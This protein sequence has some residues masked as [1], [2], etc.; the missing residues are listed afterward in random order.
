MSTENQVHLIGDFRREE[1][2]AAGTIT[3]GMLIEEDSSGEFQAHSTEGGYAMRLFAE[4]DAL[5][6]NTLDD[7]YSADDLVS[8]NVELPGNE[9][10][11]FLQAGEDVDI[12]DKLISNGDGTLIAEGSA[13]SGV[14]VK[15]IVAIA[16]EA[17]DLTGSGA[18]DTL[19]RVM[20]L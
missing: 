20:L 8:A 1:A 3:P 17:E 9:V 6:G 13:S 12:G 14:T 5:Q 2:V 18:V 7:D 11:A 19:I 15:Q 4:V 10:Q 16:R